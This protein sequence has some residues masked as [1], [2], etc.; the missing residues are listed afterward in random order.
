MSNCFSQLFF[1][2]L[3]SVSWGL[4]FSRCPCA[5]NLLFENRV[6]LIVVSPICGLIALSFPDILSDCLGCRVISFS[7][8]VLHPFAPSIDYIACFGSFWKLSL[9]LKDCDISL[10]DFLCLFHDLFES[11]NFDS[12]ATLKL[13]FVF[14]FHVISA[15][16]TSF[17]WK[18]KHILHSFLH[19]KWNTLLHN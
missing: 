16:C 5:L 13:V 17:H 4:R 19:W 10:S 12:Y 7:W 14:I 3:I 2:L 15:S 18:K 8:L 6:G 11:F 1:H 9:G